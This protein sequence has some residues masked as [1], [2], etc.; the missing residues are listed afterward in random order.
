MVKLINRFASLLLAL[1]A[2]VA[3]GTIFVVVVGGGP[4]AMSLGRLITIIALVGIYR[5]LRH[6]LFTEARHD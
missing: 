2:A 3:A 1:P 5:L 6:Y 4:T